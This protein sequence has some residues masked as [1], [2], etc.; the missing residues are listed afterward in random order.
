MAAPH[1][2]DL[3]VTNPTCRS[4][5]AQTVPVELVGTGLY[6]LMMCKI[7]RRRD[8]SGMRVMHSNICTVALPLAALEGRLHGMRSL[9]GGAK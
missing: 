8:G 5:A 7:Q 4:S 1:S 3:S 2:T 9:Q 6:I